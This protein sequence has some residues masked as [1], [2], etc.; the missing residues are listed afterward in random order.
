MWIQ[1]S[2][3]GVVSAMEEAISYTRHPQSYLHHT[4][5]NTNSC[6]SNRVWSCPLSWASLLPLQDL[7]NAHLIEMHARSNFLRSQW[8]TKR[9]SRGFRISSPT[10][11]YSDGRKRS[12]TV[13]AFWRTSASTPIK[14]SNK[15]LSPTCNY[16][17]CNLAISC[18]GREAQSVLR[19]TTNP[20]SIHRLVSKPSL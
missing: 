16:N 1:A 9:Y 3:V 8:R 20:T 10:T 4:H 18:Q 2:R 14:S 12:L 19:P 7:L 17:L 6:H 5:S 11:K 13:S 15:T